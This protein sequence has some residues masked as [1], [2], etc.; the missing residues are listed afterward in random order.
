[1]V[2]QC[3]IHGRLE[4][5]IVTNRLGATCFYQR[6]GFAEVL[7]V[8]PEQHRHAKYCCLYRVV[9]SH[10]ETSAYVCHLSVAVDGRQH[11]HRIHYQHTHGIKVVDRSLR[12]SNK[13]ALKLLEDLMQVRLMYLVRSKHQFDAGRLCHIP[14]QQPLIG[15]PCAAGNDNP[16]A[17]LR[18]PSN[19]RYI[20]SLLSNG[21]H[22]I[23]TCIA[24]H[25][26]VVYTM[27]LQ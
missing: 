15:R 8:R 4:L 26:N 2:S 9:Y 12:Q 10:S 16:L 7:V 1:M 3:L 20:L 5:G 25:G 27:L 6:T 18:E 11:A 14:R 22:A 19:L 21:V 23:K 17:A 13:S 24:C